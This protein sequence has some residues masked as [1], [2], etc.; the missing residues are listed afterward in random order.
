M[1]T[2]QNTQPLNKDS[3]HNVAL[4][5]LCNKDF[6][7]GL[8][9]GTKTLNVYKTHPPYVV[10]NSYEACLLGTGLSIQ[11]YRSF[12][13]VPQYDGPLNSVQF[14]F[15]YGS[16]IVYNDNV[17]FTYK[18]SRSVLNGIKR[19]L[20]GAS[21]HVRIAEEDINT[22][23][24]FIKL[25]SVE[26]F[27]DKPK[28][29]T[30]I[31][32]FTNS[33]ENF[34]YSMPIIE[35]YTDFSRTVSVEYIK[36]KEYKYITFKEDFTHPYTKIEMGCT[37]EELEPGGDI[38]SLTIDGYNSLFSEIGPL[39]HDTEAFQSQ[40]TTETDGWV[41]GT[42]ESEFLES[43][44]GSEAMLFPDGRVLKLFNLSTKKITK[45]SV[46]TSVRGT[47]TSM[48]PYDTENI[49]IDNYQKWLGHNN[50]DESLL[51]MSRTFAAKFINYC[52]RG[53]FENTESKFRGK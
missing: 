22:L 21:I 37:I 34:V 33:L 10:P 42:T 4:A 8:S 26:L 9:D 13:R 23:L 12:T 45:I 16:S 51:H 41:L 47:Y 11:F 38:Y 5:F 32:E 15:Y 36:P 31:T 39:A 52:N 24:N 28:Q 30:A 2:N 27:T 46:L 20:E 25:L 14:V 29:G 40:V 44:V 1:V 50:V 7:V 3:M 49:V 35:V 18:M 17:A 53:T 48:V 6:N 43:S 19:A